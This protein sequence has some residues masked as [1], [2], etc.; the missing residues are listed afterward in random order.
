MNEGL[1]RRA[2][3][4]PTISVIIPVYNAEKYLRRCIDSVLSQ[5]F[6]DFELLLIDDGSKDKS[7]AICDEYAAKDSRVRVFHKENGGVSSARN[8]GIDNAKGEWISFVDADDEISNLEELQIADYKSDMILFT[9]KVITPEDYYTEKTFLKSDWPK[10]KKNYIHHYLHFHIFSSV[11]AKLI[12]S[13]V[14]GDLRFDTEIKFGEDALFNLKIL[15]SL[16][17]IELCDKVEYVYHRETDYNVK[18]QCHIARSINTMQ[19]IFDAYW[20]LGCRNINFERNVFQCYRSICQKDWMQKP[21]L[22]NN[23]EIVKSI[24]SSIKGVYAF[25]Y[26]IKYRLATTWIYSVYQYFKS[27]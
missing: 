1:E 14:I 20:A 12:R 16:N 13:S 9:L 23:N 6:T 2:S 21:S 22:W 24:Y 11:C 18:Y 27:N 5:T 10:T 4:S 19:Q 26:R 3:A 15:A 8:L 25:D 7:G 17:E